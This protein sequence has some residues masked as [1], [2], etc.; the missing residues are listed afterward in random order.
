MRETVGQTDE[1]DCTPGKYA[2]TL[3]GLPA[4]IDETASRD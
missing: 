1:D 4:Q 2:V 3:E